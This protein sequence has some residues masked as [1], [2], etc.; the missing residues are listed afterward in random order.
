MKIIH[1]STNDISGGAARAAYRLHTGLRKVGVDSW[2]IVQSKKSDND[3][4]IGPRNKFEKGMSLLRPEIESLFPKFFLKY[5]ES[6][7][8]CGV[9][10]GRKLIN[11]INNAAPDIVHLHWICGGLLK[12]EQLKQIRAPIVWTLHDMWPFT[13]GCHYDEECGRY[14][15]NCG[16][17]PTLN[18]SQNYDLSRRVH[19]RKLK[20]WADINFT[21][22]SPSHWLADCAQ[23]SRVFGDRKVRVIP[24]GI[25]LSL[26]KPIDKKIA[27]QILSI[28]NDKSLLL[29]GAVNADGDKRKGFDYLYSAIQLLLKD[30]GQQIILA[31]FGATKTHASPDF[32]VPTYYLGKLYDEI[33]LNVIY[34]AADVFIAPSLQDNLP[35]TVIEALAC[36]TP[37]VAFNIGGMPDMIDHQINGYLAQP[38]D[39]DELT[40]GVKWVIGNA[41]KHRLS[42]N[43][44]N[45]AEACFD[46]DVAASRYQDLYALADSIG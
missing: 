21:V 5:P 34:S 43:A 12:L 32:G 10:P 14:V 15:D 28:P 13:G 2:V 38:F 30:S 25:D 3:F 6:Q 17:C 36:G 23:K 39:A 11:K 40:L 1:V 44:R 4:V 18:S 42:E 24:N 20:A 29:F 41:D 19:N 33:S 22:I 27:K 45:K 26:Y 35:N 37:C 7:F 9:L 8:N 46:L 16:K 31:I